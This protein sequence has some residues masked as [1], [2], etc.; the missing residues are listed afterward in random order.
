MEILPKSYTY[1]LSKRYI[2]PLLFFLGPRFFAVALVVTFLSTSI[3]PCAHSSTQSP[4][5]LWQDLYHFCPWTGTTMDGKTICCF[6]VF[7][8]MIVVT[9]VFTM[10]VVISALA[11]NPGG[12]RNRYRR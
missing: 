11:G 7:I 9:M 10:L 3:S 2:H 8:I 4:C 1:Y 6:Y 12:Y 5:V